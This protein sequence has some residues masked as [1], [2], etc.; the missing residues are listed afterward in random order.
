MFGAADSLPLTIDEEP[1]ETAE[2]VF[3]SQR[4]DVVSGKPACAF[5]LRYKGAVDQPAVWNGEPCRKLTAKFVDADTLKAR[6]RWACL[7]EEV[8]DD[9]ARS[10][11]KAAYI[12]GEFASALYPLNSAGRVYQVSL[13]D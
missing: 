13:A 3:V 6:G 1:V 10:G 5:E 7:P 2:S 12:E 11:G 9:I 4:D 8:R